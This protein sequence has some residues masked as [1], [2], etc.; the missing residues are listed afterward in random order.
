MALNPIGGWDF[1]LSSTHDMNITPFSNTI[2]FSKTPLQV[3]FLMPLTSLDVSI[4]SLI[5]SCRLLLLRKKAIKG[6]SWIQAIDSYEETVCVGGLRFACIYGSKM[7]R[8]QLS[9]L[10]SL[11]WSLKI[12]NNSLVGLGRGYSSTQKLASG[13]SQG[14]PKGVDLSPKKIFLPRP[15][16]A[17]SACPG[18]TLI[19]RLADS[20]FVFTLHPTQ[21]PVH[22]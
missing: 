19:A 14:W 4:L 15:C 17:P 18:H 3:F 22:S 1:S 11:S 2:L 5:F 9:N 8:C 20:F 21:E 16:L 6:G 13:V 10:L 7:C 12:V